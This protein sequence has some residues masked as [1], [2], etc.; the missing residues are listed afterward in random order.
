MALITLSIVIVTLATAVFPLNDPQFDAPLTQRVLPLLVGIQPD[1]AHPGVAW[2]TLWS[3]FWSNPL[4][5][6]AQLDNNWGELFR[7]PGIWQLLPLGVV[8]ALILFRFW[9]S[10][11]PGAASAQTNQSSA[12]AP[13]RGEHAD[14]SSSPDSPHPDSPESAAQTPP[15]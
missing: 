13:T 11:R 7:L 12:T 9:R 8:A 10:T 4:L 5:T 2:S 1:A 14:R 6:N 3:A 15:G